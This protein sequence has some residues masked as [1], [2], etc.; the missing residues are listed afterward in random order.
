MRRLH[1]RFRKRE[2]CLTIHRGAFHNNKLV[3][4]MCA[5]KKIRYPSGKSKIVY[6]GTTKNGAN[7]IAGS[8]A[9]RGRFLLDRY[10]LSH[11]KVHT[12]A[13]KG[14]KGAGTWRKLE[15]ALILN[16]FEIFG[17]VPLANKNRPKIASKE[18]RKYFSEEK[19]EDAIDYFS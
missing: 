15:A 12:V 10:R 11:F 7:R 8:A 14:V 16:F 5:Y 1:I 13:C 3:Y 18:V 17:K 6:I 19:I 4:I 2:P 9:Y